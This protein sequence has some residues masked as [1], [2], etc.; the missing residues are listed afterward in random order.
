MTRTERKRAPKEARSSAV[1]AGEALST[2]VSQFADPLVFLRELVQNS[3][4]AAATQISV[5]LEFEPNDGERGADAR[6]LMTIHIADNGEGMTEHIIDNYLLTLFSSTK[7]NDLTKIG[8]FG[9]GFVSIFAIEPALVVCETGQAGESWRVLFHADRSFEKL[10]IDEPVEGTAI[11]LHKEVTR[12]E[13]E[14]IQARARN[15][16]RYWCKYAEAEIEVDGEPIGEALAL[17]RAHL[18][19]RH[20]EPGT[21]L[22]IGFAPLAND[23][24]TA[25]HMLAGAEAATALRPLVGFYNRGLTL[26]E[27]DRLPDERSG[28]LVGISMRV[29]SRY[30]EHTLTRDNVRADESYYKAIELVRS[31]VHGM[32]RPALVEH[33]ERLAAHHSD[34]DG[35]E[36]PGA[37]D[38][39]ACLLYSRLP[40]MALG[41]HAEDA[42]IIPTADGGPLSVRALRKQRTMDG[43]VPVTTRATPLTAALAARGMRC[44]LELEGVVPHLAGAGFT[45]VGAHTRMYTATPVDAPEAALA[46]LPRVLELLDQA[47]ARVNEV[48]FG[49]LDHPSSAR[50]GALCVRQKDAFGVTEIGEDDTATLLGGARTL[51]L[52]WKHELVE[53]C[54]R[55]A[56]KRPALAAHILAQ[57][58]C[59]HEDT[60]RDRR[61][62]LGVTALGW[63]V[64]R[65]RSTS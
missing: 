33:L 13:F 62:R 20:G 40:S 34:P 26:V 38:L 27:G 21:E 16:V 48:V 41:L 10:A 28:D 29:K 11:A 5:A 60:D 18:A 42:A 37:P 3:L 25:W 44:V 50:H 15:T 39:A 45:V 22:M 54:A 57:A 49:D 31:R 59:V 61:S 65:E 6:G 56:T 32:L 8:K 17:D 58:V 4:D 53:R 46:L 14:D 23:S 47:K 7:E 1:G 35:T 63:Q 64:D 9:V 24:A 2:L 43:A 12:G 52:N 51:V 36:H 30:L 55:L 19:L